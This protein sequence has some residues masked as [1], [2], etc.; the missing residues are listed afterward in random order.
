MTRET[1]T[2]AS[3]AALIYAMTSAVLFGVGIIAVLTVPALSANAVFLIP[4]VVI[5]SLILGAPAA[6]IIA[7]RMRARYWRHADAERSIVTAVT[8]RP[9]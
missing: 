8:A 5:A 7:P 1:T 2:R 4:A 9:L 6:W 3:I